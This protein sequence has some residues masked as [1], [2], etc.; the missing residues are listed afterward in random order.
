MLP[1]DMDGN[2]NESLHQ[3]EFGGN[4][5]RSYGDTAMLRVSEHEA[6]AFREREARDKVPL[7]LS[8]FRKKTAQGCVVAC[9]RGF[10]TVLVLHFGSF[11]L[12]GRLLDGIHFRGRPAERVRAELPA[13]RPRH[14]LCRLGLF[15]ESTTTRFATAWRNHRR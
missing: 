10:L 13:R 5:C 4:F 7:A 9:L 15:R 8:V 3:G 6:K 12:S 11:S 14:A 1:A 2:R